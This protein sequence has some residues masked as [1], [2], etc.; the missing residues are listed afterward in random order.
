MQQDFEM[1]STQSPK[2]EEVMADSFQDE[3]EMLSK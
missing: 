3:Q 1:I 2:Q